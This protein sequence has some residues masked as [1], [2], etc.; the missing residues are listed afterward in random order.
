MSKLNE[1]NKRVVEAKDKWQEILNCYYE[2]WQAGEFDCYGDMIRQALHE[3]KLY[4]FAILLYNY[5][6]QVY[7]GGHNQYFD[8]GYCQDDIDLIERI[9]E[10]PLHNLFVEIFSCYA[11]IADVLTA[12]FCIA[13]KFIYSNLDS[14]YIKNLD[15]E[16]CKIK[17]NE[18]RIA[19][20]KLIT[21]K[22][23]FV[24][25]YKPKTDLF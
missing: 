17:Q 6:H 18:I 16:F 7:N 13:D 24:E 8:N 9:S 3:N 14:E 21:D 15:N 2:R 1:I 11:D 22:L 5:V 25:I 19:I 12:I 10:K 4:G 23:T 20:N